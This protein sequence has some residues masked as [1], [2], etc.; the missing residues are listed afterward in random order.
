MRG[1][2]W[3]DTLVGWIPAAVWRALRL[4]REHEPSILYSTSLPAT[5][6]LAALIVHRM[7]GLPWVADFRDA[8]T[9]DPD[10]IYTY[11]HPPQRVY[12]ALERR[13]VQEARYTTV[14][15]DS[16]SLSGLGRE[17]R[18][19][20]HIPNGVDLEDIPTDLGP[21]TVPLDRF[22]LSYVGTLYGAR[23]AGPV[24]DAVR[25]LVQ[26]GVIDPNRV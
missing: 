12:A 5:S 19:R 8:L 14:A 7:T 10:P 22:R 18:R 13:V 17:D 16:I 11:Y 6:H 15:C 26:K 4:I 9:Y 25:T 2:L 1:A 24:F 21:S 20:R 3:P 23:N